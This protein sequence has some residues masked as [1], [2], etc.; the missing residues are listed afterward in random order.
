MADRPPARLDRPRG[1]PA[2]GLGGRHAARGV[3]TTAHPARHGTVGALRRRRRDGARR[4]G[5]RR[6]AVRR[7]ARRR[8]AARRPR[9]G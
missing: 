7:G 3:R 1:R 8:R 4:R 9:R 6:R 5:G 2:E